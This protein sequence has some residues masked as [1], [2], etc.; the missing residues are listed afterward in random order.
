MSSDSAFCPQ[1]KHKDGTKISKI[2]E[3]NSQPNNPSLQ[4]SWLGGMI[5][6][7][8][9]RCF[10]QDVYKSRQ[11]TRSFGMVKDLE[12]SD[13]FAGMN[14]PFYED[15]WTCRQCGEV[16]VKVSRPHNQNEKARNKAVNEELSESNFYLKFVAILL[17]PISCIALIV[18]SFF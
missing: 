1:C 11:Q 6:W 13:N 18:W 14:A 2:S 7:E 16:A 3:T 17:I 12:D 4:P 9:P 5:Y 10:S 15:L 8:C